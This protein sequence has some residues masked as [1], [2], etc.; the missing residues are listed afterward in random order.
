MP[1]E[2]TNQEQKTRPPGRRRP[3]NHAPQRR[4]Q[5]P[6]P[7]PPQ[8]LRSHDEATLTDE[9][10]QQGIQRLCV[11]YHQCVTQVAQVN[12]RFEQFRAAVRQDALELAQKVQRISQDLQHQGQGI[13]QIRHT[14]YDMVQDKVDNLEGRFRK[15][16]E[17]THEIAA[18][19]D[20]SEHEKCSSIV[21]SNS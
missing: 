6:N 18:T 21:K 20:R 15:F 12:D 4:V 16:T 5:R 14:L 13:E 3:R 17:F 10:I 9:A 2:R 8:A 1:M 19:I 11:S 7:R